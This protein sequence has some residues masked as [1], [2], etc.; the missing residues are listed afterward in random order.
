M[1]KESIQQLNDL[2]E[3]EKNKINR[4]RF[5]IGKI[6]HYQNFAIE[7]HFRILRH[8]KFIEIVNQDG[9]FLYLLPATKL[10]TT[11]NIPPNSELNP[12]KVQSF[13]RAIETGN[14]EE[15][16]PDI[17]TDFILT[18]DNTIEAYRKI[19]KSKQARQ[20]I[21]NR[22]VLPIIDGRKKMIGI[23]DLQKLESKISEEVEKSID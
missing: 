16:F 23:V 11:N 3:S 4:L 12:N 18:T 19:K 6:N 20:L 21:P 13:I 7:E 9:D 10:K 8:L 5:V 22:E 14:F 1:E 17:V 2:T 15:Y